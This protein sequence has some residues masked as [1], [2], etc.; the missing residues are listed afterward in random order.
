MQNELVVVNEVFSSRNTSLFIEKLDAEISLDD[1]FHK[2][3]APPQTTKLGTKHKRVIQD[4]TVDQP[5]EEG[6]MKIYDL[7][8][9][10]EVTLSGDLQG[11]FEEIA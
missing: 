8:P 6:M 2:T 7:D 4:E 5:K 3:T 1:T 11:K 9:L 10:D